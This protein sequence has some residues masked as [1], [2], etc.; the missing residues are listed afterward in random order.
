M[1]SV[2][3]SME[4]VLQPQASL[5]IF[6]LDAK[7]CAFAINIFRFFKTKFEFRDVA[8]FELLQDL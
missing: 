7:Y 2:E 5:L 6:T 1:C 4:K 8:I 3:L